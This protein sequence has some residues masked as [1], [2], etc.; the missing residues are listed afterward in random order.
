MQAA[1]Q[2]RYGS[3]EDV[4]VMES[5]SPTLQQGE[6]LVRVRAAG[7]DRG[8]LH[9]MTGRPYVVRLAGY[10]LGRP[11]SPVLGTDLAGV[12]SRVGAGVTRLRPGDE[13]LGIGRG[14][15]AEFAAA[16]ESKLTLRP[17]PLTS[18]AAGAL[19]T[20]GLTA[21]QAVRD[22]A[23]IVSGH[24]VLVMGASGGVGS[25]AV[26]IAKALDAV[27]TGVCST[28]KVDL[29]S[30]IGADRVIDYS[31]GEVPDGRQRYD[32]IIDIGGNAPLSSLRKALRPEGTLVIVGGDTGGRWL[33][34]ADRQLRALLISGFVGQR[35]TSFICKENQ[36]DLRVL[37]GLV[38]EGKLH[39]VLDRTFPLG[40]TAKALRHVADGRA[41]GK[42]VVTVSDDEGAE[43]R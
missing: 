28:T 7:I 41:R 32:A 31:R 37:T 5:E 6:V 23:R 10:G 42:V 39:P 4:Q 8:V 30:S 11:K 15:L 22:H 29:V 18:E 34:G 19:A 24:E 38:A 20:S 40:D 13:V 3:I 12:V 26:Q 33:G 1:V 16:S 27:V 35:L 17:A 25:Y 43:D 36:D 14:T 21:L 2:R 9:L